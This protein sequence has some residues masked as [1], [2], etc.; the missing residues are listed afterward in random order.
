M[1]LGI[2]GGSFSPPHYGHIGAARA[3]VDEIAPDKLLIMP[4]GRSPHKT[5]DRPVSAAHRLAMARLAFAGIDKLTVSDWEIRRPGPSYTANTLQHFSSRGEL[6]FLCGTDMFL[7]LPHWYRPDVIFQNAVI[8]LA[9]RD[10]WHD[11]EIRSA[12]EDY[13]KEFGARIVFLKNPIRPLSSTEV[14]EAIARGK[15]L[16]AYLT[17]AVKEYIDA[18][19]L[20]R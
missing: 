6:F 8:V 15:D 7:T 12:A 19:H 20:Y 2:Y 1:K 3:F 14:R 10:E 9:F 11:R 18:N 17:P 13:K 5:A 16:S 4:S